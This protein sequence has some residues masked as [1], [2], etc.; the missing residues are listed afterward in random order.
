LILTADRAQQR[1]AQKVA[2]IRQWPGAP[3][4]VSRVQISALAVSL[5]PNR[6]EKMAQKRFYRTLQ[7]EVEIALKPPT[8]KIFM[9]NL[10][11]SAQF[12]VGTK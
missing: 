1:G 9:R 4:A 12:A 8:A 2:L 10:L 3:Y 6:F 11:C 7:L 5:L